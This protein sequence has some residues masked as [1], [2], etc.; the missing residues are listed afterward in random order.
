MTEVSGDGDLWAL[1]GFIVGLLL[2]GM[3]A[4]VVLLLDIK[5]ELSKVK[6]VR[7]RREQI[8]EEQ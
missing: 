1:A 2:L 4:N 7:R 8:E 5:I 3:V 6:R